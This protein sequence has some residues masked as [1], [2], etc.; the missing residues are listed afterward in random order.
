MSM[1]TRPFDHDAQPPHRHL[2]AP[3]L[4]RWILAAAL[5]VLVTAAVAVGVLRE[6]ALLDPQ[7]PEGTVQAY[8][9]AV[10]DGDWAEARSHLGDDLDADCSAIDF[11]QAWVP[12]GLTAT[13]DDV[14]VDGDE[15][16][17][18][19]RLRTAAEPDPFGGGY[20]TTET[21]DLTREGST[22]LV[23]GQPWPVYDC[24]G[25]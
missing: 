12:D 3:R 5:V 7:S 6:P 8:V 9:Q 18:A 11:R 16:E 2:H 24:R 25:W 14:K 10:L 23:I 20:A 4:S 17:V 21:F 22:W 19:I 15:A 1:T 13:L